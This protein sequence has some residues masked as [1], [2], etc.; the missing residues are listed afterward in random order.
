MCALAH[1]VCNS[2]EQSSF[3]LTLEQDRRDAAARGCLMGGVGTG[4]H[5][6]KVQ[7]LALWMHTSSALRRSAKALSVKVVEENEEEKNN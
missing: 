7:V 4:L 1:L 6:L 2:N 5:A 3:L